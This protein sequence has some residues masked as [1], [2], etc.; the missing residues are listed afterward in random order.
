[1]DGYVK[2]IISN[3]STKNE[4][5]MTFPITVAEGVYFDDGETLADK[6]NGGSLGGGGGATS[7]SVIPNKWYNKN[8]FCFGDSITAGGYPIFIGKV[9]GAFITNKGSSGGTYA[10][11][12]DIIQKTDLTYAHA[13]TF[14]TGHNSGAGKMTLETSGVLEIENPN[15]LSSYP[16]NYYGGIG[17]LIM[18][19]RKTYPNTKIYL[20][21]LHYTTRGTTS[22]DC[23][24]ALA[25]IGEYYSVPIID[26]FRNCGISKTNLSTYSS[27]GT[28]LDLLDGKG[29]QLLGE[30]VAYQMMYL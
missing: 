24:R 17:K 21:N 19:V 1:M 15:D 3:D 9:L 8:I 13:V 4:E 22:S 28:H 11:D 27:D 2:G 10:R 16:N 18:Y 14:M 20:L 6:F 12:W 29:N 7:S 30:C 26:V 25:E 5:I 23:A